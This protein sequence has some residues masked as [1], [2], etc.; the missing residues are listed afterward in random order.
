M[1]WAAGMLR[2]CV[3]SDAAAGAKWMRLTGPCIQAKTPSEGFLFVKVTGHE[4]CQVEFVSG[5]V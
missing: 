4:C 3:S 5:K 2:L 1:G